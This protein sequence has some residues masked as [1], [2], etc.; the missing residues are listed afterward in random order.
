MIFLHLL[1]L[2]YR[3]LAVGPIDQFILGNILTI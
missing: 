2:S 1:I 3:S